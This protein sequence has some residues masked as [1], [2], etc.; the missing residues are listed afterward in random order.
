MRRVF[1]ESS[2]W[3][4]QCETVRSSN[5]DGQKH[6]SINGLLEPIL[7]KTF[8]VN[9][10]NPYMVKTLQYLDLLEHMLCSTLSLHPLSWQ[11][12]TCI[13]VIETK[14]STEKRPSQVNKLPNKWSFEV[15]SFLHFPA[16]EGKMIS[17]YLL[18]LQNIG[19]HLTKWV[20]LS[21]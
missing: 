1:N 20:I 3:E 16:F 12:A 7:K 15:L 9:S 10:L 21:G 14:F 18:R 2:H 4:L 19:R 17:R 13:R 6:G 8:Q 11:C 5:L